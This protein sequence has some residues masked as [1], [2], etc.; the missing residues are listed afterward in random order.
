[1]KVLQ[2]H[3]LALP[4]QLQSPEKLSYGEA[5]RVHASG[6]LDGAEHL[7]GKADALYFLKEA[8]LRQLFLEVLLFLQGDFLSFDKRLKSVDVGK[9]HL[10]VRSDV[11]LRNTMVQCLH[12]GHHV[13]S[14]DDSLGQLLELLVDLF[15]FRLHF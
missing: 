3:Q 8:T 1:M 11:F 7:E 14:V 6:L 2:I 12:L 15:Q 9:N 4:E 10:V 13:L 5:V